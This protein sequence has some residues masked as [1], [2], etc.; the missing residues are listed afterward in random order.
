MKPPLK[1]VILSFG[2]IFIVSC[3]KGSVN[4]AENEP[5]LTNEQE[6]ES[7]PDSDP[8]TE[9]T[10]EPQPVRFYFGND[11]SYVN[12][13]E[14]CGAVYRDNDIVVDPYEVIASHGGNLVRVRLWNDPYWQDMV[15][16]PESVLD[17]RKQRYSD[18][19]DVTQTIRRSKAAGMDVLLDF[20]F[21]DIWADP[22]RQVTPNDWED[23]F[24]NEDA[25]AQELYDYVTR[26]LTHLDGEGL[27]PEIIQLG[28]ESN[29]G[30][31]TTQSLD[32]VLNEDTNTLSVNSTGQTN[33]TDQY[34]AR[35]Y[36]AGITAVRNYGEGM[37][38]P[39]QIALHVSGIDDIPYF[40]DNL[41][42]IGVT[43]FDIAGFSFY[44][45]WHPA[46]ITQM[47]TVVKTLK[48]E[49]PDYAP[50]MLETGYLW[51]D[52]NIDALSNII[53]SADEGY[54]PISKQN[55]LKYMTDLSQAMVTAG[56]IG[57]VFWE[58][59]WVSTVCRT[60]WGQGSSHEHV[61]YFDHRNNLNYHVGGQW[62]EVEPFTTSNFEGDLTNVFRVDMVDQDTTGG[63]FISGDFTE[64]TVQPMLYEGGTTYR[65]TASLRDNSSGSYHFLNGIE[66]QARETVPT[67]CANPTEP[68]NRP[69]QI[70]LDRIDAEMNTIEHNAVWAS[71]DNITPQEPVTVTLSV[72]MSAV[73]TSAG[74]YV[75][76]DL[77]DWTITLLQ[78]SSQNEIY[79]ITYSLE[80]GSEGGYYF[81]NGGDWG[82]REIVP[83]ACV[84]YY[85][86]DR[87]FW[88]PSVGPYVLNTV[89]SSCETY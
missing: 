47:T 40:Y 59:A 35:M 31:M 83:E 74:I 7:Q 87:G 61:A 8:G 72:D 66:P 53:N 3:D 23:K 17:T 68:L 56:G 45:G 27:L 82:D 49:H 76:G 29:V 13:M 28:N 70:E 78:E 5:P 43:D 37:D 69:Y 71:C 79:S 64:G 44:H 38:E 12:E 50:M 86:G 30:M 19:V 22:G 75:A 9:P 6:Q 25:M 33:H 46:S 42:R 54:L 4:T 65:Y 60:P 52:Q 55:Q 41:R 34:V 85:D 51:D 14:D 77:N 58:P 89:W 11:L 39:P 67:D 18:L 2:V 10:S 81:L 36:N 1:T 73:D 57:V 20:H 21:S 63:V 48:H 16:Q 26:V 80:A 62:M 32:V 24:N 84:G 88:V 15:P